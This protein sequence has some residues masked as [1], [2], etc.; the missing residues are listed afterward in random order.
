MA[1][2]PYAAI[3]EGE[4][5]VRLDRFDPGDHAGV[6]KERALVEMQKLGAELTELTNLL[7][8]AGQQSL[9]VVVQGRDASGKDGAIRKILEYANVLHARVVGWKAPSSEELAHDFLWRVHKETPAKGKLAIFNRSHYEDVIAVRVHQLVPEKV[10]RERYRHINDFE[11]LLAEN[12]TIVVKFY[13]H[14]SREEQ[15]K[16]LLEREVD[17]RTAWKLNV[18]D[19]RELPLW[20]DTTAAYE[21]ALSRCASPRLP[22]YLVPADR[23]W[24]RN[25]AILERLVLALRPHREG[26]RERLKKVRAKALPEIQQIRLQMGVGEDGQGANQAKKPRPKPGTPLRPK[27]A[28]ED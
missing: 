18:N 25:L 10:W 28:S 5:K 9:L 26:W 11:E 23:K 14:V 13:L 2:H 22:W 3:L 4:K 19:W 21:E 17:P 27:T 8:Y 6:D 15:V 12:D 1:R 24:F 20:D 16:R 7:A